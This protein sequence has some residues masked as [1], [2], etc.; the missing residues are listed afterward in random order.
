[1]A[2]LTPLLCLIIIATQLRIDAWKLCS[3]M[4][5]SIPVRARDIGPWNKFWPFTIYMTIF[6]ISGLV[7]TD[8]LHLHWVLPF[9]AGWHKL[10]VFF[11][12][13]NVLLLVKVVIDAAISDV[14]SATM[15]EKERQEYQRVKL[16]EMQNADDVDLN[17]K[18]KCTG[19]KQSIQHFAEVQPL[20]P[21]DAFYV[22]PMFA[23]MSATVSSMSATPSHP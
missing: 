4:K 7:T 5:R 19:N 16:F 13:E 17:L 3:L 21:G 23:T 15:L 14:S 9:T 1:M 8:M 20:R 22:E 11:F 6:N 2:P 10:T 12:V 18:V